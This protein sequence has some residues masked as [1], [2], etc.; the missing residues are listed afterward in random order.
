MNATA[1]PTPQISPAVSSAVELLCGAFQKRSAPA[2]L[3]AFAL[4]AARYSDTDLR[5]AVGWWIDNKSTMPSPA[6]IGKVIRKLKGSG[7]AAAESE[8]DTFFC[9][10]GCGMRVATKDMEKHSG[11]G[12]WCEADVRR[13]NG[14]APPDQHE[15]RLRGLVVVRGTREDSENLANYR[16]SK[17]MA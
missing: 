15:V 16:A 2:L 5:K 1:T 11:Y 17:G 14:D 8:A 7:E 6:E 9:C 3:A 4:V 12:G 13:R 10:S